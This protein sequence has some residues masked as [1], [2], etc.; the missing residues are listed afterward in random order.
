M[1]TRASRTVRGLTLALAAASGLA[2]CSFSMFDDAKFEQVTNMPA[3]TGDIHALSVE[4]RNGAIDVRKSDKL[5]ISAKL[6]MTTQERLGQA[7]LIANVGHDGLLKIHAEPPPGGWKGS[8]GCSF[9]ITLPSAVP[10]DLTT[11]NGK[12]TCEGMSGKG[13]FHTSN[14]SVHILDHDGSVKARTSN[15]RVEAQGVTGP[16][17]A[18]TSNGSITVSLAAA[19][20]GP[21]NLDTSNGSVTLEIGQSFVGALE[22]HTSNGSISI[23]NPTNI[24][25][26][27]SVSINQRDRHNTTVQFG[28]GTGAKSQI[29]TSNGSVNVKF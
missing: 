6:R 18:E 27:R 13:A 21:V 22:I 5:A 8:E 3:P 19:S 28:P 9:D 11:D 20:P 24:P 17:D 16:V 23:P 12:L 25:G 26:G 10:A 29:T 1:S 2:G 15:G 4:S 7:T 14:G